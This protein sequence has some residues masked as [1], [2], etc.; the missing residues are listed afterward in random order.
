M[1]ASI[2]VCVD[3]SP[4]LEA[5]KHVFDFVGLAVEVLV[6]ID[7]YSAVGSRW[8]SGC[9]AAHRQGAAEP[10]SGLSLIFPCRREFRALMIAG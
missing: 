6:V 4:V 5:T 1:G 9:Y 10:G 2:I 3:A 7:L 8:D